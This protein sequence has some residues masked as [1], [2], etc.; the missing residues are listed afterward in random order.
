MKKILAILFLFGFIICFGSSI[1]AKTPYLPGA[2]LKIEGIQ[3]KNY[4]IKVHYE[5]STEGRDYEYPVN[6]EDGKIYIHPR[7]TGDKSIITV[8]PVAEDFVA[9]SAYSISNQDL[10]QKWYGAEGK[11]FFDSHDFKLEGKNGVSIES[12]SNS[13]DLITPECESMPISPKL[14]PDSL[15]YDIKEFKESQGN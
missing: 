4:L 13:S 3:V 9:R 11:D 14:P 5:N 2:F 8:E 7:P 15:E 1:F 12:L 6:L 10:L